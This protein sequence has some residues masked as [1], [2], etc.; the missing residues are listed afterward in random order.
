MII[1]S[2]S[3]RNQLPNHGLRAGAKYGGNPETVTSASSSEPMVIPPFPSHPIFGM[4]HPPVLTPWGPF[5]NTEITVLYDSLPCNKTFSTV[6]NEVCVCAGCWLR[7]SI[8]GRRS[9]PGTL[10]FFVRTSYI[11]NSALFHIFLG[12]PQR[13]ASSTSVM[14]I[15]KIN[16]ARLFVNLNQNRSWAEISS[17]FSLFSWFHFHFK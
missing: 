15:K 16:Y 8:C 7:R 9:V 4:A 5:T 2:S 3:P 13:Y 14:G 6:Q 11:V 17:S 12:P 1:F 10:I